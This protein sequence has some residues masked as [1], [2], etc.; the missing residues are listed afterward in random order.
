[1]PSP[2]ADSADKKTDA[3]NAAKPPRPRFIPPS[4]EQVRDYCRERKNGIDPE[5]FLDFYTANG[6]T[7]GKGKPI[8]DWQA[9]V[10][11][12]ERRE[13]DGRHDHRTGRNDT[14]IAGILR[15]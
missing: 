14:Q 2:A 3:V 12:W 4:L 7:Q 8:R 1:M 10:R 5:A 6:W 15:F 13:K 9:A 11:T